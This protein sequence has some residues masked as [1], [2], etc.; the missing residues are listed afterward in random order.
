MKAGEGGEMGEEGAKKVA[1]KP[2]KLTLAVKRT[3]QP[4]N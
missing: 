2:E 4:V 1:L 3:G